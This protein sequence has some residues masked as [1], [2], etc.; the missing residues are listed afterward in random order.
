MKLSGGLKSNLKQVCKYA[1]SL[2]PL[3]KRLGKQFFKELEFL[4]ESQWWSKQELENYQDERLKDVIKH[5]Y[6]N[7]LYYR[8]VFK[9]RGLVPQDISSKK[10]LYKFPVLTKDIVRE[11]LSRLVARNISSR[12]MIRLNTS[13]TTGNPLYFYYNPL[14]NLS[15]IGFQS[16]FVWRQ[17]RWGGHEV[18]DPRASLSCWTLPAQ[19]NVLYNPLNKVLILSAYTLKPQVVKEYALSMEKYAIRFMDGYPSS[20]DLFTKFLRSQKISRPVDLKAIF[21]FAEYLYDWQKK[22]I[23]EYWGC[24]CFNRYGLNERVV[25]GMDCERHEGLHLIEDFGVTEFLDDQKNGYKKIVATSLTNYAMPFIRYNTE[26]YA[27]LLDRDCS[28]GRGFPLL[29]VW[30]GRTRNFAIAKDGAYV[31]VAN[32]DIPNVSE[33]VRQFQFIQEEEGRLSLSIVPKEDFSENDIQN[34]RTKLLEKFSDTIDVNIVFV[35][36]VVQTENNKTPIF[37]QNIKGRPL[38]SHNG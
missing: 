25:W 33:N 36:S 24:R 11:N 37:I 3:E 30:G 20:I 32:I 4:E 28:C 7:V 21:C 19:R 10:D 5:A 15:R 6:E 23:E 31:P 27:S 17:Y 12:D 2:I 35:D 13:G 1:Y 38:V 22:N 14:R 29:E 18:N 34:I 16:P 9:E 26:D 8:E